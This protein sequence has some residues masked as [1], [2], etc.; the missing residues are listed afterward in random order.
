MV[1]RHEP[2]LQYMQPKGYTF[3]NQDWQETVHYAAKKYDELEAKAAR[4]HQELAALTE[5]IE[6]T[7]KEGKELIGTIAQIEVYT[8]EWEIKSETLDE[9]NRQEYAEEI[10]QLIKND[11]SLAALV[12]ED[13]TVHS[14]V[15]QGIGEIKEQAEALKAEFYEIEDRLREHAVVQIDSLHLPERFNEALAEVKELLT[16]HGWFADT[17]RPRD[18]AICNYNRMTPKTR[19]AVSIYKWE[20]QKDVCLMPKPA[21]WPWRKKDRPRCKDS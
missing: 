13:G 2:S 6:L 4:A 19:F 14:M 12:L 1:D 5:D 9:T 7:E 17:G 16:N 8:S 10:K 21:A 11:P 18:M 20:T 3:R 15:R